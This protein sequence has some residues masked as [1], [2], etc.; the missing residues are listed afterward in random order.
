MHIAL[1][2]SGP[3]VDRP[4]AMSLGSLHESR[5]D[6]T[7]PKTR[8]YH[9][10]S[11]KAQ[12]CMQRQVEYAALTPLSRAVWTSQ[13][14]E[15]CTT[16]LSVPL[17]VAGERPSSEIPAAAERHHFPAV[18]AR[19]PCC[20]LGLPPLATSVPSRANSPRRTGLYC[21]ARSALCAPSPRAVHS[22]TSSGWLAL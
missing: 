7:Y 13:P 12:P 8:Q 19:C 10:A 20:K 9:I 18:V 17:S 22:L 16:R 15:R 5:C 6:V 1:V 3:A 21:L 2:D 11:G 14:R 4:T